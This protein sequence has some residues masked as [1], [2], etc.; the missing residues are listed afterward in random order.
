MRAHSR[1]IVCGLLFVAVGLAFAGGAWATLPV[2][3]AFAMGPGYVPVLLGVLLAIL[4]LVVAVADRSAP[5]EP[6]PIAWRGIALLLGAVVVFAADMRGLGFAP[7]LFLSGVM[8]ALATGR[9]GL[10]GALATG[11]VLTAVDVAL[12]VYALRLPYPLIGPW[13]HP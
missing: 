5:A 7:A 13:L 9:T 12:F 2:G 3:R 11:A 8:A 1:D 10:A 4:G 6:A